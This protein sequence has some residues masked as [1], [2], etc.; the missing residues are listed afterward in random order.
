MTNPIPLEWGRYYHIHNRGHNRENLFVEER[1][2]HHFLRL[3]PA[4]VEPFANAFAYCLLPNHFHFLVKMEDVAG[5]EDLPRLKKPSQ[6]FSNLFNACA[7]AFN[8]AYNRRGAL[9]EGPFGRKPVAATPTLYGWLPTSI[10]TRRNMGSCPTFASG[11]S[12]RTTHT[13]RNCQPG[14][15]GTRF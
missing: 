14:C 4:H 1:N 10:R 8:K 7:K 9:F 12:P 6:Y 2:Y 3:Y 11:R 15:S 5:L 13:S